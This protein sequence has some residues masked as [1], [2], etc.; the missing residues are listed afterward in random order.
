MKAVQLANDL[1]TLVVLAP[2]TPWVSL[3]VV[4]DLRPTAYETVSIWSDCRDG[5][6]PM[7][8]VP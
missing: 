6:L 1:L 3:Q 2:K 8:Y 5:F 7:R 4:F